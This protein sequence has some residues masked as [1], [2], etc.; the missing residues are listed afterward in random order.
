MTGYELQNFGSFDP[1]GIPTPMFTNDWLL[2]VI[3]F[4][5]LRGARVRQRYEWHANF[6]DQSE[7]STWRLLDVAIRPTYE[8]WDPEPW[9]IWR[10]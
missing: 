4:T 2:I 7:P 3:E 5:G 1:S 6:A 8:D 10:P 9:Q